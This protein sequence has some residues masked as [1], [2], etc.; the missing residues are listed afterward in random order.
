M[1]WDTK[2]LNYGLISSLYVDMQKIIMSVSFVQNH[3]SLLLQ[4]FLLISLNICA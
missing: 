1:I 3:V 4:I 2:E